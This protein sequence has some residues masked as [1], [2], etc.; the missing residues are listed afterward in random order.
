VD[1]KT[2]SVELILLGLTLLACDANVNSSLPTTDEG[3]L[4]PRISEA[5][6]CGKT[7]SAGG[8]SGVGPDSNDPLAAHFFDPAVFPDALCNDGTPGTLYFRPAQDLAMRDRWVIELMGGGGCRDADSCAARWC[9]FMT[10]FGM[11]QMTSSVAPTRGTDGEGILQEDEPNHPWAGYNH[12]L[13]R[14]CS[15]DNWSGTARD[16]V[17]D[18]HHP[19][20]GAEVRYRIDFLGARILDA[21]LDTLR[22]D[23]VPP[24]RWEY[25]GGVDMPDLDDAVEVVLA[26]A[27]AGGGGV[28]RSLDRIAATIATEH[29]ATCPPVVVRGLVDSSYGVSVATLD[30]S[31]STLCTGGG[32]CSYEQ[33]MRQ[34]TTTGGHA[35]WSARMDESCVE[36]HRTNKPGTEWDC[37]DTGHVLANH[38]TTPF[39]V[40]QGLSDS[41]ISGNLVESMFTVPE[42]GLITPMSFATL[43]RTQLLA[44]ADVAT[45]AEEGA[46]VP[47][48]GVF[49]PLCSKHETLRCDDSTFHTT[50][51][52]A[53]TP[54]AMLDVWNNWT[55]GTG[56]TVAVSSA[57]GDTVCSMDCSDGL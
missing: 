24:L 47:V 50:V 17:L 26:G 3:S 55:A 22:Q 13:V 38:L 8:L 52:S 20:T 44:L 40:R 19:I 25:G 1:A 29:C 11:T 9:S 42:G 16:V 53:D 37:G 57:M 6:D 51:T 41:L 27:S 45:L 35:I 48:P 21:V 49:G 46:A 23:G 54:L 2:N 33:L 30:F 36:W 28:V 10:N 56:P 14:F 32:V 12:V 4:P 5:L 39:F 34:E 31:T 7:A 43:T 18:G 15:S